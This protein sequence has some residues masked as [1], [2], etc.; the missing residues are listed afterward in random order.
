MCEREGNTIQHSPPRCIFPEQKDSPPGVDYRKNL[1]TV[2]AC[3]EPNTARSK[4]DDGH[5]EPDRVHRTDRQGTHRERR[6]GSGPAVS[7]AVHRPQ[8]A[9]AAGNFPVCE[10]IADRGSV[11]GHSE[12]GS[13]VILKTSRLPRP[14][15]WRGRVGLRR[16]LV[17]FCTVCFA[18]RRP[19]DGTLGNRFFG[20]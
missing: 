13:G 12:A 16:S 19:F 8:C 11:G 7:V 4:D 10:G 20:V 1:I 5:A 17:A 18:P 9:G 2:P 3:E 14:F 15:F 6:D